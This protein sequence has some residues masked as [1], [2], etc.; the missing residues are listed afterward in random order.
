MSGR[1]GFRRL[2]LV[3]ALALLAV[4]AAATASPL[5]FPFD[6]SAGLP[7]QLRAQVPGQMA[8]SDSPAPFQPVF[9]LAAHDGYRVGVIGIGS[10]VV[11]EVVRGHSRAMT[12]Y[13]ARGTVTP[14]RLQASFGKF[15]KVAMRFR[16]SAE[17]ARKPH[18]CKGAG[19]FM[20]RRGVFVGRVR[21][22]GEDEYL[23]VDAHRAKGQVSSLA[24]RCGRGSFARPGRHAVRPSREGGWGVELTSLSASWR[25]AVNST[26]FGALAFGDK[27]FFL[28][29]TQQSQG[30][31]AIFR[32]ATVATTRAFTI[33][34]A[35]TLARVTP[36]APFAG[37][38]TYRAAPDGTRTW[39]GGLSVNFPGAP[40]LPLTGPQ[41][42]TRL[43][44]GF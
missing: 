24:P 8:P 40:R 43:D 41:F 1:A 32:V 12:A 42:K 27:T 25:R 5:G 15:G 20:A 31:L 35:L 29:S 18:R 28:A 44:A 4:P 21:F 39:T 26:S 23:S 13:V 33:D 6:L 9:V 14:H 17:Q 2:L 3:A 22:R 19:R 37:T 30:P 34:D 16:P 38:G 10:A 36:P 7:P 11:L